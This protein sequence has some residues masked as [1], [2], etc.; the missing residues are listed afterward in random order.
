M[1]IILRYNLQSIF[2]R[3]LVYLSAIALVL[4]GA[5]S[6]KKEKKTSEEPRAEE[7]AYHVDASLSSL[8]WTAYKTTDKVPVKGTFKE[9][10]VSKNKEGA[11]PQDAVDGLEFKIP[12]SSIFT[13]DTIRD[14]KLVKFFFGV[15]ENTLELRG[16]LRMGEEQ[17]GMLSL[18]MN[19]ISKDLDFDYRVAQDTV[20]LNAVLDLDNWKAQAAL[21]SINAAC[22]EMHKGPDGVSKTWNEV[23]IEARILTKIK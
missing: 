20:I 2:M 5:Q 12:V 21:E 14:A 19:G 11:S 16:T 7:A 1:R 17:K 4:F 23:A 13:K 8:Q 15:M 3:K 6:C 18:N 10:V 9:V 22:I